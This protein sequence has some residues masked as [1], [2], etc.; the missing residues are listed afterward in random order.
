M[1]IPKKITFADVYTT[2]EKISADKAGIEG[3]KTILSND[4]FAIAE[5]IEKLM[6]KIEHT[7]R[8]LLAK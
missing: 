8:D 7:R 5:L 2:S 3:K 4:A 6:Q 1:I